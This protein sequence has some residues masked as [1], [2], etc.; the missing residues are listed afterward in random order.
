MHQRNRTIKNALILVAILAGGLLATGP[1]F[2]QTLKLTTVVPEGSHWMVKMRE[3][4][5]KIDERTEGR[6]EIKLY[7]GGVQGRNARQVQRKMRT[8]Q[9]HGGV[10]TAGELAVFQKDA[11]M[12]AMAL[13]FNDLDEARHVR[14]AFDAE[15]ERRLEDAGYVSFGFASGGFGYLMSNQ[16]VSRIEDLNGNKVWTPEGDEVSFAAFKALG[17]APVMMPITDVLTGLQ[18]DLLDSVVVPPVGAIVFQWHT[19]LKYIT[20]L[21]V[22]YT[23]GTLIID[24]KSFSR[25]S[26]PD[27]AIVR[28]ELEAIYKRFDEGGVADNREALDGLLETGLQMVQPTQGQVPE[29]REKIVASQIEQ[30]KQ[31][32]FD[33]ALFERM[34]EL[35]T[36]YRA[37]I[38]ADQASGSP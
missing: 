24:A 32:A 14:R 11:G 3:G 36:E 15:L 10:F 23:Y 13:M 31:G 17:I 22:A 38:R 7:G 37:E 19:R 9:L 34:R 12:Y 20:D 21:P 18:T 30:A 2:S 27:Q 35:L 16:P 1:A 26:E 29:W 8:G 4:A 6:V 28:E 33:L 25:L 5:S